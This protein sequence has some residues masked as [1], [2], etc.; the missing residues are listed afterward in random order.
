MI[1]SRTPYRVS[2]FGGGTDYPIWYHKYGGQVLSTSINQHIYITCRSL[3]PFFDHRLRLSYSTIEECSSVDEIMHPSAREILRFLGIRDGIEIHYDG[4][5]PSQSG[6][7][8][9]SAF[10]VGL[11]HAIHAYKGHSVS[12][13]DL[14]QEAIHVEQEILGEV[15]GSQ[16]QVSAAHGGLNKIQFMPSGEVVV[17]PITLEEDR[18]TTLENN[19]MLIYT[20]VSRIASEIASTYVN[21]LNK[22]Q[23]NLQKLSELVDEGIE[24]LVGNNNLDEFG[25]LLDRGWQEKRKLSV[26]VSNSDT[27]DIYERALSAGALGG[28]LLGAGGGGMMLL[29]VPTNKQAKLKQALS[30]RICLPFKFE[31]NGSQI[32]YNSNS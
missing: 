19:L 11:L 21:I 25:R 8:S 7:G 18:R 6:V 28:K 24:L 2:F 14:S 12:T 29:Y 3:P 1:I 26:N 23:Q 5:L 10:T 32:I 13:A 9:S 22:R 16:D 15:V 31:P 27:D 4:D 17:T 20:G 30:E